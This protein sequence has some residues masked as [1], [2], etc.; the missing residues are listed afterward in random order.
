MLILMRISIYKKA[1]C[2][3][4]RAFIFFINHFSVYI[5]Q[6]LLLVSCTCMQSSHS[7]YFLW[8]CHFIPQWLTQDVCLIHTHTHTLREEMPRWKSWR[9]PINWWRR[10]QNKWEVY[11][12]Y[13]W[14]H[15][16]KISIS[17]KIIAGYLK[18]AYEGMKLIV[19]V[20]QC[21]LEND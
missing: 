21:T 11:L 18:I 10:H 16:F 2:Q 14:W 7:K 4:G 20:D 13:A 5:D 15:G 8:N 17:P 1:Q 12:K 6:P 3:N 19:V 9:I